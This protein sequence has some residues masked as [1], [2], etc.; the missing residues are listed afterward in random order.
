MEQKM[1]FRNKVNWISF[2]CAVF[3]VFIHGYGITEANQH[4][5]A[6]DVEFFLS[7][8]V[9]L[10]AVPMFYAMSGFLF[11]RRFDFSK[12]PE[13]YKSRF[14]SLVIPY[15]FWNTIYLFVFYFI[16]KLPFISQESFSLNLETILRGVF[17][18]QYNMAY[19]FMQQLILFVGLCPVIYFLMRNRIGGGVT[20]TAMIL[21][22]SFENGRVWL[23]DINSLIFYLIGA[24]GAIH[25]QKPIMEANRF[26]FAGVLAF[27]GS[28]ILLYSHLTEQFFFL[29][30]YKFLLM[31]AMFWL[32]NLL[33][34][35]KIPEYLLVTFPIYTLH[36]LILETLNKLMGF[37]IPSASNL[38]LLDYFLSPTLT[39]GIIVIACNVV[40]KYIPKVYAIAFGGR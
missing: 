7:K 38:I 27:V 10:V 16:S 24:Y 39:I 8:N 5:F 35:V 40:K 11:Y 1:L 13:K 31:A 23:F 15:F 25:F 28:Q 32:V 22:Y 30:L 17:L 6:A 18:N 3:V 12:I 4:T 2:I 29:F 33:L 37:V 19:W 20:L 14:H 26:H 9:A 21:F 36:E 34:N